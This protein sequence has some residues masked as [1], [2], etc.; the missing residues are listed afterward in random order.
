MDSVS[1]LLRACE[2]GEGNAVQSLL[3][4]G[5]PVDCE[6]SAEITPLQ[7]AAANGHELVVRLL[8]MRGAALDKSNSFSWTPLMQAAR[9][10][11]THVVALLLQNKADLHARNKLNASALTLAA[12][13]GHLAMVRMLVESGIDLNS[14]GTYCEYTPLMAA[15]QHGHD[16]VVRFLMDRGSD[17]NY[18]T[19]STGL[20]ALMLAALNGHMT[21]AQILV[22]RGGD[23]NLTNAN[24]KT[25]LEVAIARGMREVRGYLDRKTTRRPK[26]EPVIVKPDII[27][28]A[29]NGDIQRMKEI[30]AQ[31]PTQRDACSPHDGATPL[32]F[33][34]MTGR[35]DMAQMLIEKGCDI[36]KQDTISGWTALMQATYH[37]KKN[38]AKLLI[39]AGANVTI[40]AKNGCTAFDMAS[41]I[42]DVETELL[43][44]LA[45]KAMQVNKK[46]NNKRWQPRQNATNSNGAINNTEQVQEELQPPKS[47]LKAWWSRMSNRFRNLKFGRTFTLTTN[48]LS[49]LPDP[50]AP[51]QDETLKSNASIPSVE[52]S[53]RPVLNE[54]VSTI[55]M[56]ETTTSITSN[57]S[58]E[59]MLQETKKSASVYTLGINPPHSKT[60]ND[61][62]KP[63]IPP[64]LPP[65]TFE[66]S[67]THRTRMPSGSRKTPTMNGGSTLTLSRTPVQPLKFL[68]NSGHTN[69]SPSSSIAKTH[70]TPSPGSSGGASSLAPFMRTHRIPHSASS[71]PAY[72]R[73]ES[74]QSGP[75]P[76][77]LQ[78][79]PTLFT[80]SHTMPPVRPSSFLTNATPSRPHYAFK[81]VSN[82][83]SPNSSTSGSSSLT[84]R[85]SS[86][87]KSTSSKGST[88]STLTPSPSPTPKIPE[89]YS[90]AS[91][92]SSSSHYKT[93]SDDV[94]D[95]LGGLLKNLSLERYQPI[96]EEQE[97]DMEAFL[98]LTDHDLK[99]LGISHNEPRKQILSAIT[100]LNSGKGR[101][102]QVFNETMAT[103]QNTMRSRS[104]FTTGGCS[105]AF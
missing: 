93:S 91:S 13:G 53:P 56:T 50:N 31:D 15:A 49:P 73:S 23:P 105:I 4:Q 40:P 21:T 68:Y 55:S 63:V 64:F 74:S 84:P 11:H 94:S 32:M 29:K 5:I 104:A 65:P 60:T 48:K 96:F 95:E 28:T 24:D 34:A 77:S 57:T 44:L 26:T 101:E 103:F 7:V 54:T 19:P 83:T 42:D 36:D 99:E 66:L 72:R 22:E 81:S 52:E 3:D 71:E 9:Y 69:T 8:L 76:P 41:L 20:S 6:D 75:Y 67:E 89:G 80:G 30:L 17:V 58:Y 79:E 38:V 16:T 88:A 97:V 46:D 70:S 39:N 25:A 51:P 90:T 43:R 82:T 27:E 12:R 33:A 14:C 47:G 1:Q 45:A 37:G 85:Q 61:N 86:R 62:L 102:R 59:T 2:V 92:H 78:S 18:R 100:E 87:A 10:G 35:F 98:T